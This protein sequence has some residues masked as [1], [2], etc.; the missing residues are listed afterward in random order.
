MKELKL[1]S[2]DKKNNLH[3]YIWEP[4]GKIE[5]I[6]Q[7]SHGMIEHIGRYDEFANYMASKNI[8]VIGNDHL[9]HGNTAKD[10]DDLGYFGAEKS[11]TVVDDLYEITKY[12][13][14]NYG[15]DIPYF[16]FGHSMG[17][18]MAR[19][20][21]MTYGNDLNGAILSGTGSQPS[22]VLAGGRFVASLIG[23][24]KGDRYKSKFIKNLAFGAYLNR[25]ENPK[26]ANDWLCKDEEIVEK[27]NNDKFCTFE[28]TVN[29][30]KTLFE[31][32]AF[33]Q[34]D[35]NINK[36]PKTLPVLFISGTEDPVGDYGKGVEKACDAFEKAGIENTDMILYH[37]GRHEMLNEIEREGV[38]EDVHNWILEHI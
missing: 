14:S 38:F 31:S 1:P 34:K 5:A 33:I 12:A 35:K 6:V 24:F 27:Y 16:L 25:I 9:G 13:K 3:V 21:L 30:Y 37:G 23:L 10:D 15:A 2:T 18:F 8:L 11:K 4:E 28:F 22:V 36:I 7:I 20:Y 17:S 32:I 19:R 29:G 26:T